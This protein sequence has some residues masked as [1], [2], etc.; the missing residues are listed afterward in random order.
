MDKTRFELG[1]EMLQT[2]DGQ[3]GQNVIDSLAETAPDIGRYIIEFAFGEIYR[4]GGLTIGEREIITV[5]SLLTSGG[6]DAQLEVHINAS[7]NVGITPE[8]LIEVFIQCIPYTG[9]P[10][11]LNAVVVAKKVF[12]SRGVVI[13][14]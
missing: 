8:K 14:R 7:L 6:C 1:Q 5:S 4:R 10:K 13:K 2:V 12:K 9:F 11:V 3:G